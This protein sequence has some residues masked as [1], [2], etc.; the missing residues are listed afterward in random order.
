MSSVYFLNKKNK[1]F[2]LIELLVVVSIIALLSTMVLSL[3]Q[4]A[5][6]DAK[7]RAFERQLVEI[8]TAVQL[9]R[10]N[11]NGN[12]PN[13][14]VDIDIVGGSVED[15]LLELKNDGVYPA[16][17]IK[18]A[19]SGTAMGIASSYKISGAGYSCGNP[20]YRDVYYV[21]Y[22]QTTRET[23]PGNTDGVSVPTKIPLF[24][25]N[26]VVNSGYVYCIDFR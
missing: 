3:V 11:N 9:Y 13:T 15:L 6:T 19:D 22:F 18:L 17:N 12:W 24:Y 7:W 26:G 23:S 5:R 1:G 21:I 25:E 10:E 16:S 2:T 20:G 8:R 4:K 14:M